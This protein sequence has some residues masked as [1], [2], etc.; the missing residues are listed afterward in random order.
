MISSGWMDIKEA[1][2][3]ANGKISA[4]QLRKLCR[5][6]RIECGRNGRTWLLKPEFIDKYLMKNGSGWKRP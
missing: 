4:F 3:Y 6:N 2:A 5:K 1:S